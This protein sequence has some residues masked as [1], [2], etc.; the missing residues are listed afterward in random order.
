MRGSR[1]ICE[2]GSNFDSFTA[3]LFKLVLV[4]E[5]RENP[6][7]TRNGPSSTRQRNAILMSFRWC[8][9]D[10]PTLNAGLVAL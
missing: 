2:R 3:F 4:D 10:G 8:A 9:D 5:G 7:T 6:N 1:K